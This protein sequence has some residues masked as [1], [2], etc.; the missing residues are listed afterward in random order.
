[1]IAF[2]SLSAFYDVKHIIIAF[3]HSFFIKLS[4]FPNKLSQ[5]FL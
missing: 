1:M 4:I 3:Y 5:F 2:T